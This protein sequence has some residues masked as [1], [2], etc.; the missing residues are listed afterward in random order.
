MWDRLY[1]AAPEG[2][3][4]PLDLDTA[5]AR[6][7]QDYPEVVTSR[8]TARSSDQDYLGFD[9]PIDGVPRHG[10]YVNGGILTLSDG[11]PTDWA[12]LIAWWLSQLPAGT[13]VIAMTEHNPQLTPVAGNA[14]PQQIRDLLDG[15]VAAG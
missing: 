4:W 9:L 11:T 14:T 10:I 13:P 7:H 8:H 1:L 3:R 5:E 12:D 15:L 6:L 2:T